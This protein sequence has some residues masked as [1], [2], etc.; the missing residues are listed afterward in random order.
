MFE[1]IDLQ[2][3][4]EVLNVLYIK[5]KTGIEMGRASGPNGAA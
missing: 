1:E 2:S 5:E 4:F 3:T